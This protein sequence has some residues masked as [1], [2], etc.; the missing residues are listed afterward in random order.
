MHE[1]RLR[2]EYSSERWEEEFND[3][4]GRCV[5]ILCFV[6]SDDVGFGEGIR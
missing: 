1:G 3:E 4:F 2:N 6:S 5:E